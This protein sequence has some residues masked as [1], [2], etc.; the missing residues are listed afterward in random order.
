M[1]I[2]YHYAPISGG[3]CKVIDGI[4][5]ELKNWTEIHKVMEEF[6]TSRRENKIDL[7]KTVNYGHFFF[8]GH[9]GRVDIYEQN[10]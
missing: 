6:L 1:K 3:I 9:T 7:K 5:E 2:E 8:H 10:N 4:P